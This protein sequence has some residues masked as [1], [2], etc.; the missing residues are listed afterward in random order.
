MFFKVLLNLSLAAVGL[1]FALKFLSVVFDKA[2]AGVVGLPSKGKKFL[3][4]ALFILLMLMPFILSGFPYF[5]RTL[6][7]VGVYIVLAL[8]LNFVVGF[9]GQLSIGHVGFYAV[10]AYTTALLTVQFGVPFWIAFILSAVTAALM[11]LAIGVPILRLKGDY[12]AIATIGFAEIIRLVLINWTDFTRGPAGIPGI[13]S[14]SIFGFSLSTNT[15]WY[16]FILLL[17]FITVIISY[18][19]LNSRLGRALIAIR[20]DEIA[21]EAMGVRPA[22]L[23]VLVFTLGAALAGLAGGFFASYIHY[24]NPDSFVYLESVTILMMVVLGGIGSIP[25]V[26]IGAIILTIL[27]EA[28]REVDLYRYAIYGLLLIEMM[29]VRPQ[30]VVSMESLKGGSNKWQFSKLKKSPKPSAD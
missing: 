18:R 7:I 25:G 3:G 2:T 23:K 21:A 17:V 4:L 11:G 19:L 8:S 15:H 10:G 16:Y 30:G 20:D 24:V 22:Y 14:P 26:I 12:L 5:L 29:I 13:P 9:A 27:P 1:F 28:L 6:I